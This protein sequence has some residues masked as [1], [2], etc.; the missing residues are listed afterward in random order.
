VSQNRNCFETSVVQWFACLVLV[1]LFQS[2]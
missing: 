1:C 2:R